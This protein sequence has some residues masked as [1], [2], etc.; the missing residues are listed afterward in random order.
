MKG[1]GSIIYFET[2]IMVTWI[3]N[4]DGVSPRL[5]KQLLGKCPYR[6]SYCVRLGAFVQC[7]GSRRF[8]SDIAYFDPYSCK[9]IFTVPS[10]YTF[11]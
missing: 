8:C 1:E 5:N 11:C 4:E 6:R 9:V 2:I 3:N 7:G 10:N